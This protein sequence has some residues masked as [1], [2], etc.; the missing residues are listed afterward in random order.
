ML[1]VLWIL[2]HNIGVTNAL[3]IKVSYNDD[4]VLF[5]VSSY[6]GDTS[7]VSIHHKSVNGENLI[8]ALS[9]QQEK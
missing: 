3:K 4:K 9:F 8:I 5:G 1:L 2:L 6:V 7:G